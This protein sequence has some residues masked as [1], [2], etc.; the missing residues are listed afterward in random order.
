M[1]VH[2]LVSGEDFETDHCIQILVKFDSE[3]V[4]LF[5]SF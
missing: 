1:L 5:F 3:F 4:F 2:S